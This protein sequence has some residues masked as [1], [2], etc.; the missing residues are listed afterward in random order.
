[1]EPN[2]TKNEFLVEDGHA[3]MPDPEQADIALDKLLQIKHSL[4]FVFWQLDKANLNSED[5]TI[6][7]ACMEETFDD[8]VHKEYARLTEISGSSEWPTYIPSCEE[9]W[10]AEEA[11]KQAEYERSKAMRKPVSIREFIPR[12]PTNPATY[13]ALDAYSAKPDCEP[14]NIDDKI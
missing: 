14:K 5:L 11:K 12:V 2:L 4:A 6:A 8:L 10:K 9:V 7:K 1:M 13:A 3:Y